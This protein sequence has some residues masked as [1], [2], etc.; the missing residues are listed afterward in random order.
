MFFCDTKTFKDGQ[1][2]EKKLTLLNQIYIYTAVLYNFTHGT[3]RNSICQ[4]AKWTV[5]AKIPLLLLLW[6]LQTV[7]E[8]V[9]EDIWKVMAKEE[10]ATLAKHVSFKQKWVVKGYSTQFC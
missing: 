7:S 9:E 1:K 8:H 6:A 2:R 4:A 5:D 10:H 3:L